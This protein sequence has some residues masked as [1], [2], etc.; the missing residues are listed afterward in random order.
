LGKAV[1]AP[2]PAKAGQP[3]RLYFEQPP[4]SGCCRIYNLGG[5]KVAEMN[6][7]NQPNPCIAT[8]QLAPGIYLARIKVQYQDGSSKILI[9]KVAIL[10]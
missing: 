10:K 4:V 2:V 1:L 5:E 9:Q 8:Q 6:F 3:L 7:E